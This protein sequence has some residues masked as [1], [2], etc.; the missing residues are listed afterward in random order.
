ME[1]KDIAKMQNDIDELRRYI[2][3]KS[4]N[5]VYNAVCDLIELELELE[6]ECNI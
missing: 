2:E 1:S 3:Q 5:E 4:S 6:S